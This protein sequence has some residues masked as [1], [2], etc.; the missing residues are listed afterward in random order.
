MDDDLCRR[1]KLH[2]KSVV[3][4]FNSKAIH[5]HGT[6]KVSGNLNKIFVRNFHFTFDELYYYFKNNTHL[7]KV[8]ILKKK[9]PKY[10]FKT[11]L[12]L[13][14]FRF[15]KSVYYLSKILAFLKFILKSKSVKNKE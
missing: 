4:V 10:L 14:L 1:I 3:Q 11:F 9:L 6:L 13:L 8:R 5:K 2:K 12:N 7:E 15:E